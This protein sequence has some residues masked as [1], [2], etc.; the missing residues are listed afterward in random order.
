MTGLAGEG[1]PC[2]TASSAPLPSR[3]LV[4]AGTVKSLGYPIE[5]GIAGQMFHRRRIRNRADY[6]FGEERDR[7]GSS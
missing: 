6:A 2:R 7:H 5:K 1:C 4:S 3:G